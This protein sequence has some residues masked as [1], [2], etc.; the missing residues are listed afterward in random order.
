MNPNVTK[1]NHKILKTLRSFRF[2]R[3]GTAWYI[4]MF[5]LVLA[6]PNGDNSTPYYSTYA[7]HLV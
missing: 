6:V 4:G 1:P 3:A 7:G 5:P 2:L